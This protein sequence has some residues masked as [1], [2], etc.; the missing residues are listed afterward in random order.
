MKKRNVIATF[1][2]L[3]IQ[4][5][6]NA[7]KHKRARK[8]LESRLRST[9]IESFIDL[10]TS[11]AVIWIP[12]QSYVSDRVMEEIHS[13]VVSIMEKYPRIQKVDI[14]GRDAIIEAIKAS[15][16]KKIPR[17]SIIRP[18][19]E[20]QNKD[21]IP[22]IMVNNTNLIHCDKETREQTEAFLDL[23]DNSLLKMKKEPGLSS[24]RGDLEAGEIRIIIET[25]D[26][27]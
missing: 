11:E 23:R 24:E 5:Q 1:E 17:S 22:S 13:M 10:N 27:T 8:L 18:E 9:Y 16:F 19:L 12:Y 7:V 3:D 2:V 4:K 20:E 21:V 6:L 15:V 26:N 25:I 14:Y